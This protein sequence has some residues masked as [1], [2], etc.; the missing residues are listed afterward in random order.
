MSKHSIAFVVSAI[1]SGFV[2]SPEP[3]SASYFRTFHASFCQPSVFNPSPPSTGL[4]NGAGLVNY[5]FN[6]SVSATCPVS[7]E[8]T[9]TFDLGYVFGTSNSVGGVVANACTTYASGFVTGKGGGACGSQSSAAS[10]HF[11]LSLDSSALSSGDFNYIF[12]ALGP[13][14]GSN[15]NNLNEIDG[16]GY[17]AN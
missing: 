1:A 13:R 15:P 7:H 16:Y 11:A 8:S 10:G 5:S 12:V 4:S 2:F 3:A 14:P 9:D 6:T 17:F